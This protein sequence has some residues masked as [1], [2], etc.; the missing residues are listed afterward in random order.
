MP[1]ADSL[2]AQTVENLPATQETLVQSLGQEDPLEKGM[3]THSSILAWRIPWTKEL[4]GH[5][6]WGRKESDTTELL[7]L[8]LIHHVA[9]R[10][11]PTQHCKAIILSLKINEKMRG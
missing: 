9:V 2:V 4:E 7:T 6:P 5:S 10:Q 3:V 8:W 11:K 1:T